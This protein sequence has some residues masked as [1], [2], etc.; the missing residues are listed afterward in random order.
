M[1]KRYLLISI[2]F[3]WHMIAYAS[4]T[5]QIDPTSV[6]IGETFRLTITMDSPQA[7]SIPD[8][9][10]LQESFTI[11]G[12]ERSMAYSIINGQRHSVNQWMVLLTPIKTGTLLIPAIQI[13]QLQ[14]KASSI[15]VTGSSTAPSKANQQDNTPSDD[16]WLKADVN[17][18]NL[19]VN[20]Q[21]IYTVR[22]Y[23]SQRLLDAEYQPPR[24]EDALM[25]P[26]GDSRHYQTIKN[27]RTYAVEEQQYAVFPQRSGNISIFSPRFNA[28]IFDTG[29]KRISVH[30]D[31]AR[32]AVK[33]IP[34]D[35][36]GKYWLPAKQLALTEVYDQNDTMM[37]E[38]S[39]LI[40]TI[41]LQAA[42]VPAQ[43]LP[44][45]D[46]SST[47][48]YNCYPESPELRSTAK[49]QEVIGR[50][51]IKVTYLLNK[52]G[53]ITI[54]ALQV[55]WFN[56]DTGKEETV[57]LPARTIE[58]KAKIGA[59]KKTPTNTEPAT[60]TV[61]PT[62]H[63]RNLPVGKSDNLAWWLAGGFALA[64]FITLGLWWLAKSNPGK[65]GRKR[66]VLKQLHKACINNN[67]TQA[68]DAMLSLAA[69]QWPHNTPLN[70][71]HIAKLVHDTSLKKE[72]SRLSQA[73]YSQ[74]KNQ[75]WQGDALWRGITAYLRKKPATKS[76]E[77]GLPPINPV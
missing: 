76:K 14:T 12:T 47:S 19:Y 48:D 56:T 53:Q 46:F 29:P 17:T 55:H 13:G 16:V 66:A 63:I 73:L 69:I 44:T 59:S 51:D 32:L 64:W 57:S 42:G 40:R 2:L 9:T 18:H 30:G 28:V 38:G 67:P 50:A 4:L 26:L 37:N 5:T 31:T 33:P 39:T 23:T 27:N 21:A 45:L 62:K 49:Q 1:M 15:D 6:Q 54:P 70:L 74:D 52:P 11:V 8:L 43:L 24:I 77:N 71:H 10:P 41:T 35:Y 58:V 7:D 3:C 75:Q 22:L 36:K 68:Q 20:Q 65:G 61:L 34:S 25:I 60:K 72:L